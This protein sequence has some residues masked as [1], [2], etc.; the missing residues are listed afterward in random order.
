MQLLN[1]EN[2]ILKLRMELNQE[3]SNC[4][5]S[6]QLDKMKLQAMQNDLIILQNEFNLIKKN[7]MIKNEIKN[8][9]PVNNYENNTYMQVKN[10]IK[11]ENPVVNTEKNENPLPKTQKIKPTKDKKNKNFEKI[12]GQSIMGILASLLIFISLGIFSALVLPYLPDMAKLILMYIASFGLTGIGL[13]LLKKDNRNKWYLSL[14]GCGIGA[15]YVSL[16]LSNLYFMVI[17]DILLY[18]ALL[19]WSIAICYLAKTKSNIFMFIGELGIVISLMFG[20]FECYAVGDYIQL[21]LLAAFFIIAQTCYLYAFKDG[22]TSVIMIGIIFIL[23]G[24]NL[25]IYSQPTGMTSIGGTGF[26]EKVLVSRIIMT[27]FMIC[28]ISYQLLISKRKIFDDIVLFINAILTYAIFENNIL[29]TIISLLAI[30]YLTF[31]KKEDY[32]KKVEILS[33]L[34]G[35][36]SIFLCWNLTIGPLYLLAIPVVFITV[37]GYIKQKKELEILGIIC[38]IPLIITAS[39]GVDIERYLRVLML[40]VTTII[41]GTTC[42][43]FKKKD[44]L[45][46]I[47]TYLF[48]LITI[49]IVISELIS[50]SSDNYTYNIELTIS[51]LIVFAINSF[52]IKLLENNNCDREYLITTQIVNAMIMIASLC[53]IEETASSPL[54]HIISIL[55]AIASFIFNSKDIISHKI[56]GFYVGIKYTFLMIFILDS[57]NASN[58]FISICC[59]LMA[60][61]SIGFGLINKYK[62]LRLFGLLLSC[63]SVCKLVLID[64]SYDSSV[65]KAASFLICGILCFGINMVYNKLGKN[66]E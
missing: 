50:N 32:D 18:I 57:F 41:L 47:S 26:I 45:M 64:I 40:A 38:L 8:E 51:T 35:L 62:S 37:C 65:A 29:F 23:Y 2:R 19:I 20:F 24:F 59:F 56:G 14:S 1:L 7:G 44:K 39:L 61:S 15:V 58:L 12:I 25:A 43:Q 17:G 21:L 53:C 9:N 34:F 30:G 52:G 13:W 31:I 27:I 6:N 63:L 16:F 4:K 60:C 49:C 11:N 33:L 10:E 55:I 66:I 46:H 42:I 28:L 54:L 3:V 5:N 36:F 48:Q 22:K